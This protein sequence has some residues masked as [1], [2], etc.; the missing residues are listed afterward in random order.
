MLRQALVLRGGSGLG[1]QRPEHLYIEGTSRG[2]GIAVASSSIGPHI[3]GKSVHVAAATTTAVAVGSTVF[4]DISATMAR[5]IRR[6]REQQVPSARSS[7]SRPTRKNRAGNWE[8][9]SVESRF[10]S[11]M[12]KNCQYLSLL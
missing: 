9:T 4:A 8:T 7:A 3:A 5:S 10:R 6:G 2:V 11:I 1:R 12:L